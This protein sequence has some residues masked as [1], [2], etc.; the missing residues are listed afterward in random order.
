MNVND[1][2]NAIN[3][4]DDDMLESV[5]AL[6]SNRNHYNNSHKPAWIYVLPMVACL[7]IIVSIAA[8]LPDLFDEHNVN[9]SDNSIIIQESINTSDNTN[10]HESTS[11]SD[12]IVSE[13]PSV[14]V[15]IT[16]WD[17][18]SFTGKVT[19][20]VDTDIFTIGTSVT[21]I[22]ASDVCVAY[23][24]G[25]ETKYEQIIP[26]EALYPV[27]STLQVQFSVPDSSDLS[28]NTVYATIITKK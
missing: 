2:H 4:I 20:L 27:G 10:Q 3:Q 28:N 17:N 23:E 15:E 25:D 12:L 8:V 21:V 7:F 9:H 19:E 6:R 1:L 22:F 11:S 24:Y 16:Q 26:N 5:D 18:G 13:C 14:I